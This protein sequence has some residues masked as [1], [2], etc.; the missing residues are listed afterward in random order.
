M[1]MIFGSQLK[2]GNPEDNGKP[3][4]QIYR[5]QR[6]STFYRGRNVCNTGKFQLKKDQTYFDGATPLQA[7]FRSRKLTTY[8]GIFQT[9]LLKQSGAKSG[10]LFSGPRSP[11]FYGS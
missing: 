8:K 6:I 2:E 1:L 11:F 7:F 10:N 9:K 3:T 4:E 5:L